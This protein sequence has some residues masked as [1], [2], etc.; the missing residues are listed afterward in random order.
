MQTDSSGNIQWSNKY[1]NPYSGTLNEEAFD[2][3]KTKDQGYIVTGKRINPYGKIYDYDAYLMKLKPNGN[4]QWTAGY[5]DTTGNDVGY[6]VF[7]TNDGGYIMG[8]VTDEY[9]G[10]DENMYLVKT[11]S[12][13]KIEWNKA[14][15][16]SFRDHVT[17]VK[18]TAD[19]GYIIIGTSSGTQDDDLFI[20]KL[21][22]NGSIQWV[23]FYGTTKQDFAESI[24][25]TK[26]GGYIISGFTYNFYNNDK[27]DSFLIKMDS[28]GNILWSKTYG[29]SL[30]DF[31]YSALQTNDNGY[32][33]IG[34]TD[35]FGG[36]G[37]VYLV[38]TDSVGNSNCNE[39]SVTL[40]QKSYTVTSSSK[41]RRINLANNDVSAQPL[42]WTN[43]NGAIENQ[44]CLTTDIKEYKAKIYLSIYPNPATDNI[45]IELSEPLQQTTELNL[46][47]Y[48]NLGKE[49]LCEVIT[50]AKQQTINTSC[51]SK[52]FYLVR[53]FDEKHN[54]V[55]TSQKVILE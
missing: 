44:L 27:G 31:G 29:G 48:D 43:G 41:G 36:G 40:L 9:L 19:G 14:F 47:L 37:D 50:N 25:L 16:V 34:G 49:V 51:L 3:R 24:E 38:K 15:D 1:G 17:S 7:Q 22:S 39:T 5:G 20:F 42:Y 53:L 13:G 2:I 8:G 23:K 33:L 10:S 18:Q 52:G 45:T 54:A 32:A 55:L 30:R 21:Y 46:C 12:T 28:I 6:S 4:I 26:D 11:D 35:S